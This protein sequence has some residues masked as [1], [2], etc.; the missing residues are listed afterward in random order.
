MVDHRDRAAMVGL[1]APEE[2]ED[3]AHFLGSVFVAGVHPDQRIENDQAGLEAADLGGESGATLVVVEQ[4]TRLAGKV[5]VAEIFELEP[6]A[7]R[8]HSETPGEVE[9][10]ALLLHDEDRPDELGLEQAE[11]WDAGRD[12]ERQLVPHPGLQQ[13]RLSAEEPDRLGGPHVPDEPLD[14]LLTLVAGEKDG[15]WN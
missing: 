6:M 7:A 14:L 9:G 15:S 8:E 11:G 2:S 3:G 13:L 1:Q 4:Q 5:E 10:P 12:R